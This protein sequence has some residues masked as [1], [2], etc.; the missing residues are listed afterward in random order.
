MSIADQ[1]SAPQS[2]TPHKA[3]VL[4]ALLAIA[5]AVAF[6]GCSDSLEK[7]RVTG[8]NT[9][10]RMIIDPAVCTGCGLCFAVCPERAIDSVLT[11]NP[12][13]PEFPTVDFLVNTEK[14]I[15]CG[16]CLKIC[17]FAAIGWK[18]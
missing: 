6:S 13:F 15:R 5:I 2:R 4:F 12:D 10:A 7:S 9:E 17:P 18:R 16:E 1:G 8:V 3:P 11:P 14:C